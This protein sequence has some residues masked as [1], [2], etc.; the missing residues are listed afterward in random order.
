MAVFVQSSEVGGPQFHI[1][2]CH[3]DTLKILMIVGESAPNRATKLD[4]MSAF[5]D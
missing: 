3:R 2:L 4:T 1:S 5:I